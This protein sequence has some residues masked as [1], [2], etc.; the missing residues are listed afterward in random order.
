MSPSFPLDQELSSWPP[1]RSEPQ[2]LAAFR[3]EGAGRDGGRLDFEELV[4]QKIDRFFNNLSA[5]R[6]K[7]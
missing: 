5:W 7:L 3:G 2:P 6:L 4:I 1:G